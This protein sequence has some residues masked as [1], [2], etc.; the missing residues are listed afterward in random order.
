MGRVT[1]GK[2]GDIIVEKAREVRRS[3]YADVCGG[4]NLQ[5]PDEK[6]RRVGQS[7]A[8]ASLPKIG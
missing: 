6:S 5:L 2:G 4:I 1:S 7:V 8:A 3:E